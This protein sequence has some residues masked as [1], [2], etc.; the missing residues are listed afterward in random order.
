MVHQ[1]LKKAKRR[2]ARYADKNGQYTEFQVGY[3]VYFNPFA[4][5]ASESTCSI[6]TIRFKCIA[7]CINLQLLSDAMQFEHLVTLT[8]YVGE[9]VKQQQLKSKLQGRWYPYYRTMDKQNW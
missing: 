4:C 7:K 9:R 5:I 1:H 3:P 2:Q 6:N 8:C